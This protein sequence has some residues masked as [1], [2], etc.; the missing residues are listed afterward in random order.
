VPAIQ[1]ITPQRG[2]DI[3]DPIQNLREKDL[4][5][6][7]QTVA[8]AGLLIHPGPALFHQHLQQA[9]FRR[10]RIQAPQAVAVV[11]QQVQ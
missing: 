10:V 3:V 6:A 1:Q 5:P 2:I 4:Q 9:G 7:G 11:F 8:L